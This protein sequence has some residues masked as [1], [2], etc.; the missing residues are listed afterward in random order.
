MRIKSL[1]LPAAPQA[2]NR[3][4][5]G[6]IDKPDPALLPEEAVAG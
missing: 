3:K 6:E 5:F 2:N 1:I 4:R